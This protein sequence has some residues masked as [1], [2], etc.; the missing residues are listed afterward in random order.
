MYIWADPE[1]NPMAGPP[2]LIS[3]SI[4]VSKSPAIRL[5]VVIWLPA[6]ME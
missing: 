5:P 1:A 3:M 6:S 4:P 2:A